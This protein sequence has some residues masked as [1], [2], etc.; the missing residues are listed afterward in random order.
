M[1]VSHLRLTIATSALVAIMAIGAPAAI[2]KSAPTT[3]SSVYVCNQAT[4]HSQG[5]TLDATDA[6]TNSPAARYTTD[7]RAM[8]GQGGGLTRAAANSPAL[9]QCSGPVDDED[10][11]VVDQ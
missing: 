11:V 8:P 4:P 10:P 7:L 3:D 6:P 2:A 5:G 1:F 9:S